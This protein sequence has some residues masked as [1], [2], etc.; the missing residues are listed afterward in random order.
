[1]TLDRPEPI[2]FDP[3]R[4]WAAT[5]DMPQTQVDQLMDT[6]YEL[7]EKRDLNALREFDF[8]HVGELRPGRVFVERH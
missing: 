1:M 8:I 5:K 6:V 7:A 4:F 2:W 3:P